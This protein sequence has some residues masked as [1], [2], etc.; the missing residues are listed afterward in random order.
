MAEPRI[1]PRA[2]EH[3]CMEAVA[4]AELQRERDA[5]CSTCGQAWDRRDANHEWLRTAKA[6][7][8]AEAA[9]DR[10]VRFV[11][12]MP[13]N[14]AVSIAMILEPAARR[15]QYDDNMGE[16]RPYAHALRLAMSSA[17]GAMLAPMFEEARQRRMAES[18]ADADRR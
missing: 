10:T 14:A 16:V 12:T 8:V 15:R 3:C 1:P 2:A 18:G 11:V 5:W 6:T 13:I 9:K 17:M 7:A 4:E